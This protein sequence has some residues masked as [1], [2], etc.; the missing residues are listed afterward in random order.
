VINESGGKHDSKLILSKKTLYKKWG[1][2]GRKHAGLQ[3]EKL[4]GNRCKRLVDQ[5]WDTGDLVPNRESRRKV[6][7]AFRERGRGNYVGEMLAVGRRRASCSQ[8]SP[9][10]KMNGGCCAG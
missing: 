2:E 8:Y 5:K 6:R 7:S 1:E 3:L 4:A 10:K 9:L